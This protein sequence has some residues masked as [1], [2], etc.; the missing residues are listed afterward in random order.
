MCQCELVECV[1]CCGCVSEE[2][3][4]SR[5][6]KRYPQEEVINGGNEWNWPGRLCTILC[7]KK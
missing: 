4:G 6:V 1:S 7:Y 2:E 5:S 3:G